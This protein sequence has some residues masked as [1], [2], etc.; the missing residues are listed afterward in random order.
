MTDDNK[1]KV[2]KIM[3]AAVM[4]QLKHICIEER[5]VP[6][7]GNRE[8]TVKIEYVGICGSDLHYY[9]NGAIGDWK[10]EYPFVLGH[11]AAG[12]VVE[13]GG[14]VEGLKL[15]DRV[16]LEPGRTCGHCEY[17]RIGKC[18]LCKSVRFFATPPVDGTLQQYVVCDA[19]LCFKLP[20]NISTLEG[21]LLE[22]LAVGLHGAL[23]GKAGI[24]QTVLI[25]GAGCIGLV[26]L[27][28]LKA[29]GV[30]CAVVCDML[31][32][33]LEKA[34]EL[35]ADSVVLAGHDKINEI[36]ATLNLSDGFD[37]G[38]DTT[39]SQIAISDLISGTK[40]GG[41]LVLV[42]Y[43]K[44]QCQ[45]IPLNRA[46][47]KELTIKTVFRYRNLYPSAIRAVAKGQINIKRI[48]TK[49]YNFEDTQKAFMENLNNKDKIVK[50]VI[51]M[52]E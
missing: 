32:N 11:E 37:L 51:A 52:P 23:Q 35:G 21:A 40:K 20:E 39:G 6:R 28:A 8:V 3:K 34:R 7:P 4:T 45:T 42:G 13:I 9:E 2:P 30:S 24:G 14:N 29:A 44:T 18:N 31:E 43:G 50:S 48:V 33:R 10:V 27:M 12:T 36:L 49:I 41:T 25:M 38:V 22:P 19:A 46:I 15:G 5:P 16:A 17:C 47:D 1:L 26:T